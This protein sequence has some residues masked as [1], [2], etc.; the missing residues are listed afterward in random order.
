MAA[1]TPV[2]R[3][4]MADAATLEALLASNTPDLA[5]LAAKKTELV[6]LAGK[7]EELVALA[8]KSAELLALLEDDT[9]ADSSSET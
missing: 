3:L 9:P 6:A 7:A 5:A 8:E 4:D 1:N 2:G